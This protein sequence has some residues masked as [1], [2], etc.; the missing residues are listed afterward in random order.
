MNGCAARYAE[1]YHMGM[2]KLT[3]PVA[4]RIRGP[5]GGWILFN[6][7]EEAKREAGVV[8]EAW[9]ETSPD[10]IQPPYTSEA[11]DEGWNRAM[12]MMRASKKSRQK[13]D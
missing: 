12:E 11:I 13:D 2:V 5:S 1:N 10:L 4:W 8:G 6:T 3:E 7:L 9:R